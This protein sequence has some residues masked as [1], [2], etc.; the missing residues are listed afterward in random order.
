[1]AQLEQEILQLNIDGDMFHT[2]EALEWNKLF[3]RNVL[4][5]RAQEKLIRARFLT[6]NS[7][8]A[9]TSFF[10]NL[11][12]KVVDRKVLGCLKLPEGRRVTDTHGIISFALSFYED[13][14]RTEPCDEVMA[15]LLLQDLPHLPENEKSK[16]EGILTF[17]DLLMICSC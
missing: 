8:D 15:D 1:M 6:F 7:M 9:P 10:F 17:N 5:E 2:S 14:Y 3:L 11:E 12:K 4:D 16:L 13:L